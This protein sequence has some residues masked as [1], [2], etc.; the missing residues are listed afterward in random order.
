[1]LR[2]HSSVSPIFLFFK[3]SPYDMLIDFRDGEGRGRKG[4]KHQHERETL[5]GCLS[6]APHPG[7]AVV[8]HFLTSLWVPQELMTFQPVQLFLLF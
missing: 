5:I 6:H 1:M 8:Y 7:R 2:V 3:F 4:G